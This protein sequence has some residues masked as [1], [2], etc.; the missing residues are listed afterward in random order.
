MLR[1]K[2]NLSVLV[3]GTKCSYNKV[4]YTLF[5]KVRKVINNP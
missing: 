2:M 4:F 5:V 1:T 3:A